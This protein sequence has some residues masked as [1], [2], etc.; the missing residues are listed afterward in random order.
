MINNNDRKRRSCFCR[1]YQARPPL[2]T[3]VIQLAKHL[4]QKTAVE[5][6]LLQFIMRC[7]IDIERITSQE[8]FG[9]WVG[10]CGGSCR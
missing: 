2:A 5:Q 6:M 9:I 3:S 4:K 7:R 10:I 8:K 1:L